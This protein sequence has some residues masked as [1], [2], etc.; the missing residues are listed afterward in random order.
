MER[1]KKFMILTGVAGVLGLSGAYG[2]STL[3]FSAN[4][5]SANMHK[6]Y[7]YCMFAKFERDA[8]GAAIPM[9][10]LARACR[11][12]ADEYAARLAETGMTPGEVQ[13]NVR[14]ATANGY[15]FA[16]ISNPYCPKEQPQKLRPLS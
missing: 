3:S 15:R 9:E 2:V 11:G 6:G 10:K 14:H 5:A 13:E 1:F 12:K 8:R 4:S 16:E 7:E